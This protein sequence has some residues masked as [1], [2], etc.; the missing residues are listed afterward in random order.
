[1]T[2][3]TKVA[4]AVCV[5]FAVTMGVFVIVGVRVLGS[6]VDVLATVTVG[7]DVRSPVAVG[8]FVFVPDGVKV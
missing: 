7:V 8:G 6:G 4:V 2:I 3:G 1:L 5:L